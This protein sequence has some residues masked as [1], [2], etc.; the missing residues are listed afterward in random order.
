MDPASWI[1]DPECI[2]QY[3]GC[4]IL[5]AKPSS[6]VP[7]AVTER[8]HRLNNTR[9]D[10]QEQPGYTLLKTATASTN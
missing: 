10:T 5:D 7:D 2:I 1:L 8:A 4:S 9:I 6:R 3:W